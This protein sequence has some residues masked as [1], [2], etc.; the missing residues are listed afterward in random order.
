MNV[1]ITFI[2]WI[3][4]YLTFRPQF[5]K[6]PIFARSPKQSYVLSDVMFTNT[7]APQGTVL[8]PFLFTIY[9]TDCRHRNA[10]CPIIKFADDTSQTALITSNNDIIYRNE[11]EYFIKWCEDNF[12][13][14][15]A[16]KTKEIIIDFSRSEG[17]APA[18]VFY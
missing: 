9:T 12:L 18:P 11:V 10:S 15:N 3:L 17:D 2:A 1:P 6:L 5:V 8:S 14:L 13:L 4:D 7:G 16:R